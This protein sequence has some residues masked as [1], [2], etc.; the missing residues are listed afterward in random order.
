MKT[1]LLFVVLCC[2]VQTFANEPTPKSNDAATV[3]ATPPPPSFSF[4]RGHKQGHNQTVNWG[5]T[6]NAGISHFIV[7]CTYE[8]PA[9][10]YSVWNSVGVVPCTNMPIFK[11]I[12]S[13][14]LP[15]TL[16]YRIKAV[17]NDNSTMTSGLYTIYIQ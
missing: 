2:S 11:F 7:E 14:S 12:D 6:N 10:P 13:P 5:M 16:N 4:I 3:T 9:D 17:M 8:D 15:G 1:I